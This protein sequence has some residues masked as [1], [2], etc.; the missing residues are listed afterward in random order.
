MVGEEIVGERD[1]VP[2]GGREEI[3]R[4]ERR[5]RDEGRERKERACERSDYRVVVHIYKSS[6]AVRRLLPVV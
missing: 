5:Q 1:M 6:H 2:E 3:S 4:G